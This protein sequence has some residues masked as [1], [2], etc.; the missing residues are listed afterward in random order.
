MCGPGATFDG[1]VHLTLKTLT[2]LGR[3]AMTGMA[4]DKGAVRYQEPNIHWRG[5]FDMG[6]SFE[7][8]EVVVD[9]RFTGSGCFGMLNID[10]T[11]NDV[12]VTLHDVTADASLFLQGRVDD[13]ISTVQLSE[14]TVLAMSFSAGQVTSS[15]FGT[16]DQYVPT[17]NDYIETMVMHAMDEWVEPEAAEAMDRAFQEQ[18]PLTIDGVTM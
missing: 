1:T 2:G 8:L 10:E 3:F 4:A 5:H 7:S 18:L 11:T 13:V 12:T 14:S 9:A 16:L 6:G 15:G 17:L